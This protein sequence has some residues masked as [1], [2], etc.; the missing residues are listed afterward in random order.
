[1]MGTEKMRDNLRN[2]KGDISSIRHNLERIEAKVEL[3]EREILTP[4]SPEQEFK[5][6]FPSTKEDKVLLKL[7]G[8]QPL[9]TL[10]QDKREIRGA[11]YERFDA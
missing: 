1:M 6:E 7:V 10:E 11:V 9:T 2:L 3:I 5:R 8:T 4:E